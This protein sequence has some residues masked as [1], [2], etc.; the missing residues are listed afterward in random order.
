MTTVY[1]CGQKPD[2]KCDSDGP[3]VCGG[4][5]EDGSTWTGPAI[6][7]VRERAQWGSVTCSK[8]GMTAMDASLWSDGI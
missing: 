3:E 8:C 6:E 2:H 1:I 4:V 7:G 5:N